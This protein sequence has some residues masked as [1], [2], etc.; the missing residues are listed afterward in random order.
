MS[1]LLRARIDAVVGEFARRCN[2][3][4]VP[5]WI[6]P[7]A[8]CELL[9]ELAQVLPA[10]S[11]AFEFGSGRSSHA[12]RRV[13]QRVTSV[14]D[15][16]EWLSATERLSDAV[17]RR[18]DDMTA[19]APLTRCWNQLRP[20]QS[21]DLVANPDLLERL[22]ASQLVLVDSPPNPAKREH[23]L[24]T[25][26]RETPL[27]AV[28][29]IDDL[30]VG[31]TARFTERLARQNKR[32]FAFWRLNI[33]HQLGLFLKLQASRVVRS[34]PSAREFVGTWLRA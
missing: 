1:D 2:I 31:A 29:V 12:L 34:L 9:V 15:S 3:E 33:D 30:E 11:S 4:A 21:F 16:V 24:Y 6:L 7:S 19:V 17:P 27:H 23:A 22:Q 32:T 14:E 28:V 13:F 8:S 10:G 18:V 25:A 5:E 20:I 26:L